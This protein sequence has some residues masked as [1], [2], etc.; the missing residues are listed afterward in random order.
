MNKLGQILM[1]NLIAILLVV[2]VGFIQYMLIFNARSFENAVDNSDYA[3]KSYQK[4]ADEFAYYVNEDLSAMLI[5]E[6]MVAQDIE[7]Y[8]EIFFDEEQRIFVKSIEGEKAREFHQVIRQYLSDNELDEQTDAINSLSNLLAQKYTNHIFPL[9]ELEI[10]E[11]HYQRVDQIMGMIVYVVVLSLIAILNFQFA[12]RQR[13]FIAEGFSYAV[14]FLLVVSL[15]LIF[16]QPFFFNQQITDF[17][18]ALT[19][20]ALIINLAMVVIYGLVSF[21]AYYRLYQKR[22]RV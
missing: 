14:V 16:Y 22:I 6:E 20:Q 17:I 7:N 9:A 4:I 19:M 3:T 10:V 8:L 13:E 11:V 15:F 2:A 1:I 5:S 18:R 12:F 21:Y